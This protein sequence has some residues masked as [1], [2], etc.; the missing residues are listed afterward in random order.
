MLA[1]DRIGEEVLRNIAKM[2]RKQLRLPKVQA[3]LKGLLLLGLGIFLL[4]RITSG[5]L[6][7]YISQRFDWLT[8]AAV[9]G[10]FI[11]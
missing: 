9:L 8:I 10:L 3:A 1:K 11:V 2:T 6:N 7:F 5:T 4:T